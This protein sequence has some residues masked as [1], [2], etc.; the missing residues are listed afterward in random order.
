MKYFFTT[1]VKVILI[2]AVLLA[3]GLAIIG[4]LTGATPA[5]MLVAEAILHSRDA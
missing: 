3:G 4:N 2:L 5:D 1:K